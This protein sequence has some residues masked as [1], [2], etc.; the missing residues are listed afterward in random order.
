MCYMDYLFSKKKK[1]IR[2]QQ[3]VHITTTIVVIMSSLVIH[4][5]L[6][7]FVVILGHFSEYAT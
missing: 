2:M 4:R 3:N 7:N 5:A 6:Q 1:S